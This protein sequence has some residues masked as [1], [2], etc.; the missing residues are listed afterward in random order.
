MKA[1]LFENVAGIIS[2]T[3]SM[4]FALAVAARTGIRMFAVAVLLVN[5]ERNVT[6][7]QIVAMIAS[8]GQSC[9]P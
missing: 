6:E 4:P 7:K 1:R 5:S 9:R 3:G 8:V 2:S